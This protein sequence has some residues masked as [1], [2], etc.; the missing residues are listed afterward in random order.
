MKPK[1]ALIL[2]IYLYPLIIPNVGT[3]AMHYHTKIPEQ[4]TMI[5]WN[6]LI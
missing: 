5:P 3:H 1:D 4:I 2:P 6:K